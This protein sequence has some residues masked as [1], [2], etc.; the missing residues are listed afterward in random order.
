[1]KSKFRII[2]RQASGRTYFIV[3]QKAF[4]LFWLTHTVFLFKPIEFGSV[5][6][7]TLYIKYN[8][9]LADEKAIEEFYY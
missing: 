7:A 1:M 6:E 2:E 3:Q 8:N 5:E 4:M 9:E